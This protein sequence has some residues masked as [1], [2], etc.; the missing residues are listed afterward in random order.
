VDLDDQKLNIEPKLRDLIGGMAMQIAV[1]QTE[2]EQLKATIVRLN[3][4][5]AEAR[6]AQMFERLAGSRAS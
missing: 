6:D 2:N 4:E 3:E 5:R 1:L